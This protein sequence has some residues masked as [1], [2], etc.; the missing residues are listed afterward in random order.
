M[1]SSIEHG[2]TAKDKLVKAVNKMA[3]AVTS[4]LGPGGRNVMIDTG[5]MDGIHIT[6]DGVTVARSIYFR[7]P[8]ENMAA[9]LMKSVSNGSDSSV[10]DGTTTSMLLAQTMINKG[11][12]LMEE[13]KNIHEFMLGMEYAKSIAIVELEKH[14][15]FIDTDT[16][17]GLDM[18]RNISNISSNGDKE[19]TDALMKS[20]EMVG[21]HGIFKISES[22]TGETKIERKEGM[23]FAMGMV[24]PY[25]VNDRSEMKWIGENVDILIYGGKLDSLLKIKKIFDHKFVNGNALNPLMIIANEFTDEIINIG[26]EN[27]LKNKLPLIF[28]KTPGFGIEQKEYLEDIAIMT[29]GTA[30]VSD[31][32]MKLEDVKVEDL[33]KANRVEVTLKNFLIMGGNGDRELIEAR[34][35]ELKSLEA[36]EKDNYYRTK[37]NERYAKMSNGIA[38]IQLGAFSEVELAEKKYRMEDAL[39][40]VKNSITNGYL[41]GGGIMLFYLY[42]KFMLVNLGS[43]SKSFISGF[44]TVTESFLAPINKLY[45]NLGLSPNSYLT[46]YIVNEKEYIGY[47]L[48]TLKKVN[49][50]D[51]GIIDPYMVTISALNYAVSVTKTILTTEA[52]IYEPE[53]VD[54]KNELGIKQ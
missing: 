30:I 53:E 45:E 23:M 41:P 47:D 4:T 25:M 50:I 8:V 15:K 27:V 37:Y 31:K 13:T 10:G 1:G 49:L 42:G 38:I 14:K 9:Q 16:A 28:V 19:I 22:G 17:E 11:I 34:K 6:K 44:N 36:K 39:K 20:F 12:V 52:V 54:P 43:F 7:D 46:K 33:G 5:G 3:D 24:S 21:K 40:A 18:M 51:A 48:K 29:G 32:N 26:V 2:K 35:N